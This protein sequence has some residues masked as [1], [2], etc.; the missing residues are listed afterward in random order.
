[1]S[2]RWAAALVLLG[3]CGDATSDPCDGIAGACIAV[4]VD[5][6]SVDRIDRLELDLLYGFRHATT[7][8]AA[9]GGA[10]VALPVETA[11]ELDLVDL[12]QADAFTLAVDVVAA[13]SLGGMVQGI[14]AGS[15]TIRTGDRVS[16]DL[17]LAPG[18][19]CEDGEHHCGGAAFAGVPET[20]YECNEDGVPLAR[21]RCSAGCIAHPDGDDV[22]RADGGA[23]V[24]GAFYCG[25]DKLDGDPRTLYT[26]QDG[27]G[28]DGS[29]CPDGCQVRPG[30]DDICRAAP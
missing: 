29:E 26:C 3:A 1:M 12:E 5:S 14:G 6:E 17:A 15:A 9:E 25:G 24:E 19:P 30:R 22:C 8:T 27:R 21:G 11:I 18:S 23:C 7:S 2:G 20:L 28:V 10:A 16:I 13:G 4:R